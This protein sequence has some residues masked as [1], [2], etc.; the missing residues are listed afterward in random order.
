MTSL[1]RIL[2]IAGS[3]SGGGAGI[4]AD[5]RT[6]TRLGGHAMTAITALTAQN[7]LDVTAVKVMTAEM[8]L[9]Q[10]DAVASDIGIDAVKIGML[11]SAENAQAVADWLAAAAEMPVI[12]DPVMV[13]TSGS[14]LADDATIT[15]FHRIVPLAALVTPNLAEWERLGGDGLLQQGVPV[16]LK[17]GHDEDDRII[18]RLIGPDGEIARWEGERIE[19]RHNHGT[20]CTLSSAIATLLG[21][22]E[23]LE[24]AIGS[25][26]A[27]VRASLESAPGFGAGA[28]PMG[29]PGPDWTS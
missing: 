16:L 18:D 9:A 1:P 23:P 22:G 6:I 5:I 8:V 19:T 29:V 3:D 26:I 4:Q 7:T 20:G 17:G 15:A 24:T 28:G 11:G 10:I 14:E 27:Y 2:S 25:A 21:R 12:F 13:A